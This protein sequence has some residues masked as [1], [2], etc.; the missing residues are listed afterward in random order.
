MA[1]DSGCLVDT[2]ILLRLSRFA[3]PN[4]HPVR[5]ALDELE[6]EK[7]ELFYSLQNIAEFWNV[8]TRPR[9]VNGFG[10]SVQEQQRP[11]HHPK[12][13]ASDPHVIPRPRQLDIGFCPYNGLNRLWLTEAS[14][15]PI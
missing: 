1:P 8:S 7:V 14:N 2:N 12:S 10:L 5:A 15:F 3:D 9:N 11:A 4:F 13:S 6:D